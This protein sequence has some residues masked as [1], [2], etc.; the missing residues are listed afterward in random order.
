MWYAVSVT[1]R[2]EIDTAKRI[3]ESGVVA[4]CPT[5]EKK[6]RQRRH[7]AEFSR[8]KFRPLFGGYIFIQPD[9]SFRKD[10]FEDSRTK[11]IVWWRV[12]VSEQQMDIVRE[13]ETALAEAAKKT[14]GGVIVRAGDVVALRN[15]L[16]AGES[17]QVLEVRKNKLVVQSARM[18]RP[19]TVKADQVERVA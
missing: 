11:L 2:Y 14:P 8:V 16:F 15:A 1:P 13:T 17:L 10:A 5:V 9:A 4:Y 3:S 6:Y 7:V 12:R 18:V 19:V